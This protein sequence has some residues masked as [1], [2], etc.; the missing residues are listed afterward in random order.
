MAQTSPILAIDP[1]R[2]KCG[3][4]VLARDAAV[5]E[6]RVVRLAEL[7]AAVRELA[8]RYGFS[9]VALGNR[10]GAEGVATALRATLP[11][12]RVTLM[13]EHHTTELARTRYFQ[14]HPPRGWRRLIPLGLQT[15]PE[16]IDDW[17]AV[18]LGERYLADGR[19][20]E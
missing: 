2:Y 9:E 14:A 1:G 5:L 11:Q 3:L 7:G 17:A 13:D 6:R 8:G 18:V 10:T 16:S 19:M 4:A 20:G 12:A 15:P